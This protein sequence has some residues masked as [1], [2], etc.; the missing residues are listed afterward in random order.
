MDIESKLGW[1]SKN[2]QKNHW[3]LHHEVRGQSVSSAEQNTVKVSGQAYVVCKAV[4]EQEKSSV[5]PKLEK[6]K[7]KKGKKTQSPG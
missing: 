4:W 1:G 3:I 6:R 5:G 2:R 7:K